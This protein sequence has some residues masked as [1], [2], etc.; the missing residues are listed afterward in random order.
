MSLICFRHQNVF[1]HH[2]FLSLRFICEEL[3][4]KREEGL[5]LLNSSL[6]GFSV[7]NIK[8]LMCWAQH[9]ILYYNHVFLGV[10]KSITIGGFSGW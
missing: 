7:S 5:F 4:G 1:V 3:A 6:L 8:L 9:E 10:G 2:P